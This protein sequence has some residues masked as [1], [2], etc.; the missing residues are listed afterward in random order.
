[1][2]KGVGK[3]L[4]FDSLDS[5]N[6]KAKAVAAEGGE[7]GTVVVAK[8]QTG[9]RGR[10]R[11]TWHSPEGGL[12]FSVLLAPRQGRRPTDLP[13]LA[14]VAIAQAIKE[15]LPKATD[16]SLKWPNDVLV[17]WKKVAGILCEAVSEG[18]MNTCVVGIGINVNLSQA[19]LAPF[20]NNP[21]KATSF[22]VESADSRYEMEDCLIVCLRK[23]FNLYNVYAEEGF[24]PVQYLWEKNCRF[25]GKKVELKESAEPDERSAPN[26][27]STVGT[28]LGID[29][30]GGL[31]L[32]NAKGERAVYYSGEMTC[33]WP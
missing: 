21:F 13:I 1:M 15:I 4:T 30:T 23:L 26:A 14:G 8:S 10:G 33:F 20:M 19:E 22:S 12:Y 24:G 27:P 28:C 7:L 31:V 9:G 32:S 17:N 29:E 25:V 11:R 6:T 18:K 2:I 5:T 16:V 3:V